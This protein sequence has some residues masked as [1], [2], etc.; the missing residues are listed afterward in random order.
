MIAYT[1]SKKYPTPIWEQSTPILVS[2]SRNNFHKGGYWLGRITKPRNSNWCGFLTWALIDQA[3]QSKQK[4]KSQLR[5]DPTK[6]EI[7]IKFHA[8]RFTFTL[9]VTWRCISCYFLSSFSEVIYFFPNI[10]F[11]VCLIMVMILIIQPKML[12]K[13]I[14]FH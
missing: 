7:L 4:I 11:I 5:K 2:S 14:T 8:F 9:H 3:L 1:L 10:N 6:K 12:C 13:S